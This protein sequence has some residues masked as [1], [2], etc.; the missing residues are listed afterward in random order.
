[1]AGSIKMLEP[2][3]FQRIDPAT[4]RPRPFLWI[5]YSV[6]GRVHQESAR[7]K[8]I[9]KAR[10]L[11]AL[12]IAAAVK[13][14]AVAPRRAL[15]VADI[16]RDLLKDMRNGRPSVRT[17]KGHVAQ[18]VKALGQHRAADLRTAHVET[19]QDRWRAD[20]LT[21]ATI[22]RYVTTL[23]RAFTPACR[24]GSLGTRPWLPRLEED[25]RQGREVAPSDAVLLLEHLPGYVADFFQFALDNGIRKA[26]LA[27][28]RHQWVNLEWGLI[29]WPPAECKSR[30]PHRLPLEGRSLALVERLM[31]E[32]RPFCPYLFHGRTCTPVRKRSKVYGCIGDFR[33]AWETA[34]HRA[35][36]PVGRD[37]DGYIFHD[38]R[39]TAATSLRAGGMEEPDVMKITGH[40]PRRCSGTTI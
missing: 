27:R 23:G 30:D 36:L 16:L 12:R 19:A 10:T 5:H 15:T 17:A 33:K 35:G 20:G 4:G 26:Q 32:R 29:V 13:G 37:A 1:M 9:Q 6:R 31:A 18:L 25:G 21:N 14:E 40:K 22:N 2:G 28:T 7:T 38:T 3:I 11:R 34:C 39:R 24:K 8:S